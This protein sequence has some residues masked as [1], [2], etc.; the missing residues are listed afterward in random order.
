MRQGTAFRRCGK[1]NR[2]VTGRR[3]SC[4]HDRASWGYTVDVEPSG[5]P[6]R[7]VAKFG[8]K[9][10]DEALTAMA[11]LQREIHEGTHVEPSKLTMRKYLD[12]WIEGLTVRR[13]VDGNTLDGWRLAVKHHLK[14]DL[15]SIRLQQLQSARIIR[16]YEQLMESGR[17]D[18]GGGLSR[19]S[20]WNVHICLSRAMRDAVSKG[21]IHKNPAR[22]AM[23]KPKEPSKVGFWTSAELDLFLSWIERSGDAFDLAIYQLATQTGMRRGELLGLRWSDIDWEHAQ[24]SIVQARAKMGYET[25]SLPK[26]SASRRTVDL[27]QETV[28]VL[29]AHQRAQAVDRQ[30]YG[31]AHRTYDLVFCRA[32][33]LPYHPDTLTAAFRKQVGKS[34]VKPITLHDLRHTSAVIGLRELGE[35][36]DEVSKR[37]GHTSV[38]FTLDT[39]GHLLPQRG[40]QTATAFDTLLKARRVGARDRSVIVLPAPIS[41]KETATVDEAN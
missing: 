24:V 30:L 19:K 10:K 6:R 9:T 17:V 36:I 29:R 41:E 26:T 14:P 11:A 5:A 2:R 1:C 25:F 27:S 37:L 16:L 34:G 3:C 33:G 20:V 15:G 40:R 12:E 38:A 23:K 13:E 35:A 31:E 39:Y 22:G 7:Q 21:L 18:E 4:G 8:F 32:D 28:A